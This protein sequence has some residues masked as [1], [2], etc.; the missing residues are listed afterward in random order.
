MS[1]RFFGPG[2]YPYKG[3]LMDEPCE[4]SAYVL[5]NLGY[6]THAVHDNDAIFYRRNEVYRNLGFDTF[7]SCEFMENQDDV[8][9]NNWM[10]DRN[11]IRP[12]NDVLDS[13]PGRDFILTVTVQP[14]GAYP[15]E[16]RLTDPAIRVSGARTE[17]QNAAW[18]YYVNQL[19]EEDA[20]VQALIDDVN[21]RGEP[22]VILFYGDHLPTMNLTGDDLNSGSVYQTNYLIWDN[23][24]LTRKKKN[25][26][27]YQ[28]AAEVFRRLGIYDGVMFRFQQ[29][30]K[31]SESYTF[32]MQALQYD[33]LYGKKYV[34][35]GE[36][37]Y[38]ATDMRMGVKKIC[39]NNILKVG[40]DIIYYYGTNFTPS[41]K[42]TI[43]NK[44]VED[45]IFINSNTLATRNEQIEPGENV[46]VRVKA[47]GSVLDTFPGSD[48]YIFRGSFHRLMVD[49]EAMAEQNGVQSSSG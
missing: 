40:Q 30:M 25:I 22:T 27:A 11:L 26:T 9:E 19:Y 49:H 36:N 43:G 1:L 29:T 32:D 46:S 45:T 18:E 21:Q 17:P 28:A 3:V 8:N 34:Y 37:P 16:W 4:S 39:L 15:S 44:V 10:R 38:V 13:T 41:C 6:R 42:I 47:K 24:G 12:I 48:T 31:K 35:R 20:F 7:T 23:M 14:H 33:L 2:E 5:K